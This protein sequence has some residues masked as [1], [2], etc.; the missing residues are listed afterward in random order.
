VPNAAPPSEMGP[1]TTRIL[2][3]KDEDVG[4]AG[5]TFTELWGDLCLCPEMDTAGEARDAEEVE[6]AF[7]WEWW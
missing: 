2:D 4:V 3:G 6:D 1:R 5:R 7:E